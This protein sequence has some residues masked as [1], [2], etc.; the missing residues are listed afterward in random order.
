MRTLTLDD[1]DADELITAIG[2]RICQIETGTTTFRAVDADAYNKANP[3]IIR[4]GTRHRLGPVYGANPN[5]QV[6]IKALDR[7]QRDL[8]NRLEDAVEQLRT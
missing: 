5:K 8:I 1:R 4:T 3:P 7:H 2:M 6:E